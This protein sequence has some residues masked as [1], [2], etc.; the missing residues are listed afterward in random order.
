MKCNCQDSALIF[1]GSFKI[2]YCEAASGELSRVSPR[3]QVIA[4]SPLLASPAGPRQLSSAR[5]ASSPPQT[6]RQL[7]A[8][9]RM[10]SPVVIIIGQTCRTKLTNFIHYFGVFTFVR[11]ER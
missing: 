1:L 4:N 7:A 11:W 8:Y 9:L 10:F 5:F 2:L 3:Q 6:S